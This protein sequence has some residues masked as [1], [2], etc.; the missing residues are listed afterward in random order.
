MTP[1]QILELGSAPNPMQNTTLKKARALFNILAGL[2]P[3]RA[4]V[5]NLTVNWPA[6][7]AMV[8]TDGL[9]IPEDAPL[10]LHIAAAPAD[11]A[12]YFGAAN[13]LRIIETQGQQAMARMALDVAMPGWEMDAE[14]LALVAA[15]PGLPPPVTS[16]VDP[17]AAAVPDWEHPFAEG[18]L[19]NRVG[20]TSPNGTKYTAPS[21]A[22]WEKGFWISPF[23]AT[24][25]KV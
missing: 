1:E 18:H 22:I 8:P 24:W 9:E 25:K 16:F 14:R 6:E 2:I 13:L 3:L 12:L 19:A 21:G 17:P 7:A 10:Y 15:L 20:D 4:I 5:I 11:R 23:T